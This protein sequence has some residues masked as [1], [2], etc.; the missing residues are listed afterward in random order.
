MSTY[1]FVAARTAILSTFIRMRA[2]I[3][4]GRGPH[5]LL[6]FRYVAG[7]LSLTATASLLAA[8]RVSSPKPL[9]IFV[10]LL[11]AATGEIIIDTHIRRPW[12]RLREYE[13]YVW[14]TLEITLDWVGILLGGKWGTIFNIVVAIMA[15]A[16]LLSLLAKRFKI[17][18][19]LSTTR[20]LFMHGSNARADPVH[21]DLESLGEYNEREGE[22]EAWSSWTSPSPPV[23]QDFEPIGSLELSIRQALEGQ[24][25]GEMS[26]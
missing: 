12:N 16:M 8:G 10:M 20:W 6:I 13:G 21:I 15:S 19:R 4:Q 17:M 18:E 24:G 23:L 22:A 9:Q 11:K 5:T 3:P 26:V 7:A 2:G 25:G 14:V 1:F